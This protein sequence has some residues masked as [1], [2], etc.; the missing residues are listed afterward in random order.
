M[1]H[2]YRL[3]VYYEDTDWAGL[4]YYANYFKFIERART[5]LLRSM[6]VDQLQLRQQHGCVFAV[7]S[8]KAEY[9]SP[10]GFDDELRVLSKLVILTPARLTLSQDVCRDVRKLFTCMVELA[11]VGRNG[12]PMRI[13]GDLRESLEEVRIA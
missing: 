13:P 7:R 12:R 6:G 4:V 11:C 3:R 5:E 8:V 9:R 1:I 10:A 2:E